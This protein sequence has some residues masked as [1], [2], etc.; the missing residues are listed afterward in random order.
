[1]TFTS[2]VTAPVSVE[3]TGYTPPSSGRYH[4]RP[5]RCTPAEGE[6]VELVVTLGG[7][8]VTDALPADVLE[9]LASEALD[10]LAD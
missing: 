4:D 2:E 6:A 8:D 1:M 7:V 10:L 5:E 3:V 9:A